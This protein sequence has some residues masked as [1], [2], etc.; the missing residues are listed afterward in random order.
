MSK[1]IDKEL[2]NCVNC[3]NR[4]GFFDDCDCKLHDKINAYDCPDFNLVHYS[5]ND[6]CGSCNNNDP[7]DCLDCPEYQM[8]PWVQ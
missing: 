2:L 5:S 6:P 7:Y 1:K 8:K 3:T 4:G